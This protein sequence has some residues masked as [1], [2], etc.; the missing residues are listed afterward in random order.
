MIGRLRGVLAG[1][2]VDGVLLDVGGVGYEVAMP[3]RD[4]ADL[5]PVGDEVV[6]HTHT[7]VRE[8]QLALYGFA[9]ED[10][11]DTFRV[12]VTSPGVGPKLAMAML[13]TLTPDQIRLAVHADD[14]AAL[15][16]VPGIG[17]RTAQKMILELRNRLAVTADTGSGST[18]GIPAVR[19]ALEGL[20]YTPAEVR[21]AVEGLDPEIDV[22]DLLR[23]ALQRMS[24]Q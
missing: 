16:T 19:E 8:D 6:I 21:E 17:A 22:E 18:A 2:H 20:G 4:I 1:R 9:G 11:R 14:A 5:P 23:M 10:A 7:H 3:G 12:L 15:T 24:R 13:S